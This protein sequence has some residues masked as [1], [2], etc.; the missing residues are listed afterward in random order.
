MSSQEDERKHDE[1]NQTIQFRQHF[2]D[3][4]SLNKTYR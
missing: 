3:F 4:K 1:E 2:F